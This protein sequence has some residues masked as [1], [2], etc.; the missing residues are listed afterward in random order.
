MGSGGVKQDKLVG[1]GDKAPIRRHDPS[2]HAEMMAL[3]DAVGLERVVVDTYQ[4][5]SGT[6]ADAIAELETQLNARRTPGEPE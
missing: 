4:S 2:A 6:G 5:V 3:R 1:R